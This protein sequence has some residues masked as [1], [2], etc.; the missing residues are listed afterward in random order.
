MTFTSGWA[1]AGLVLLVP[2]VA[3]HLRDRGLEMR[4]VPSL[5]LWQ[6]LEVSSSTGKRR[7]RPPV[8]PLLLAL[9]AIALTLLVLALA[10]PVG[11]AKTP[12]PA[13]VVVLDDSFWMQV[14]GRLDSAAR[15]V[16][17]AVHATP[18]DTPVRIVLAAGAPRVLYRGTAS[19]VSA[20]LRRVRPSAGPPDL[21]DA[22]T[23]AAGLLAGPRD[24]VVLIRA[25]EDAV[26]PTVSN[27]GELSIVTAGT[28][29]TNQGIF[30][31]SARCGIG[32]PD[33]CEVLATV[34]N[35]SARAVDDRYTADAAGRRPLSLSTRV[36]A[37]TSAPIALIARPGE[38]VSLHLQGSDT[39]AID[40][41][42]WVS[43]PEIGNVPGPAVVTLVGT[44]S[45]ALSVARAFAAVPG[46][47]LRLRT[48]A[49]YSRSDAE[50]SDLV[51]LDGWLPP[52]GLP[53]S[54]GVVL[55]DP[56]R[57]PG[58]HVGGALA[59]STLS[60]TDAGGELL[61]RVDL[62]SLSI[63][64]GSARRVDLP[65]WLT[66]VAWSPSGPLLAAGDDG[67]QR[68]AVASF[69]PGQS[70]LPQ[71]ASFPI[72]AANLVSWSLGWAPGSAVAG[73]PILVDAIPGARNATLMRNGVVVD[74]V[75]LRGQPASLTAS[76]PGLYVVTETGPRMTHRA[77]IAANVA[78]GVASNSIPVDI[79]TAQIIARPGPKPALAAWF[80]AAA[81]V[82]LLLEWAY[83]WSRRS[84]IAR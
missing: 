22:L 8:L 78:A 49:N 42:A 34:R 67:R 18:A 4:D 66:P 20:A 40:N 44:P 38:Q 14:P 56:P 3:L 54:P 33:L 80:V 58:G 59:D 65:S 60:G 24:R 11:S 51:V 26:P 48:P 77:T 23:V 79:R 7:L 53:P 55:L 27:P 6:Q 10:E 16:E 70:D 39:L 5:L 68:V 9:Q 57:L 15:E 63:E 83:W 84:R 46:I 50:A 41:E 31:A 71:L 13:Q 69:E 47:T 74:R 19:G 32:G 35:T 45:R 37:N 28:P 72:L 75:Q 12:P 43:V 2:L 76:N 29:I 36:G 52:A 30:D 73:T 21:S 82:V 25:P 62:S 61:D 1:L 17:R 81:F 64:P